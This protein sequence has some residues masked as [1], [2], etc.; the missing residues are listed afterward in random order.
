MT[1]RRRSNVVAN[2][3]SCLWVL[4][5]VLA[6]GCKAYVEP[7][8]LDQACKT[9][10]D[11][12]EPLI[13]REGLRATAVCVKTCGTNKAG[14]D[15]SHYGIEEPDTSCPTGWECGGMLKQRLVDKD[16]KEDRG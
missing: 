15:P 10:K 4:A 11:C 9:D 2:A 8:K 3:M 14:T 6:T 16:T 7:K 12:E 1:H 5:L 13:C